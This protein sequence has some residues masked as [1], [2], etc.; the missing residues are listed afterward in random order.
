[1]KEFIAIIKAL[2]NLTHASGTK[3][4]W[5]TE[6]AEFQYPAPFHSEFL[7][8]MGFYSG[9]CRLPG[10]SAPKP[11]QKSSYLLQFEADS[12][13]EDWIPFTTLYFWML[14]PQ[15]KNSGDFRLKWVEQNPEIIEYYSLDLND[16]MTTGS[17][18]DPYTDRYLIKEN[19]K[20]MG[21]IRI[22]DCGDEYRLATRPFLRDATRMPEMLQALES[23]VAENTKHLLV[24]EDSVFT[25]KVLEKTFKKVGKGLIS[26][27]PGV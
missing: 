19:K 24:I 26:Y 21:K 11:D 25:E 1:M 16:Q 8:N 27:S 12:N 2:N 13:P 20:T 9:Y 4:K 3:I 23:T 10:A 18:F 5:T 15:K 17:P 7:P 14:E 6:G 22:T